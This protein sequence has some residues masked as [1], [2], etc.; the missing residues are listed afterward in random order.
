MKLL[1]EKE[2]HEA[3]LGYFFSGVNLMP[4]PLIFVGKTWN[5]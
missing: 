3:L 5:V 2:G 1:V 4:L